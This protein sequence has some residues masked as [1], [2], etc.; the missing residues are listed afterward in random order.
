MDGKLF[1][2]RHGEVL[3]EYRGRYIGSTDAPLDFAAAQAGMLELHR[4]LNGVCQRCFCSPLKRAAATAQAVF[5]DMEIIYDARL[6]EIDFGAWENL[7]FDEICRIAGREAVQKWCGA[8]EEM[9]FP[10]GE[11][12][13]GFARRVDGF[14]DWISH[15]EYIAGNPGVVTH[16]GVIM[17]AMEKFLQIPHSESIKWLPPRGEMR[18]LNFVNGELTDVQ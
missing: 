15:P 10:G 8:P 1:L 9:S 5:P 16:G 13:P 11:D 3:K 12:Y 6:R 14:F 4:K 17:R 2:I 7:S 18:I